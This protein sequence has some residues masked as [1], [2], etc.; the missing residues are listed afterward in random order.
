MSQ[1]NNIL[2]EISRQILR[3]ETAIGAL[4][5]ESKYAHSKE[6]HKSLYNDI[7]EVLSLLISITKIIKKSALPHNANHHF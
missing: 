2:C 3:S 6:I 1:N 4:V 5:G 7:D